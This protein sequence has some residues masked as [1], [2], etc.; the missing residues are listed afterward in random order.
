MKTDAEPPKCYIRSRIECTCAFAY[1]DYP[2]AAGYT[3]TV[4]GILHYEGSDSRILG[5]EASETATDACVD[6]NPSLLHPLP[7]TMCSM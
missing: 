4:L 6:L 1:S 5:L 2:S 7:N 3:L